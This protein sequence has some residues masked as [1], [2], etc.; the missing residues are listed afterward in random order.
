KALTQGLGHLSRRVF[1]VDGQR[2]V[3]FQHRDLGWLRRARSGSLTLDDALD[4]REHFL[5]HLIVEGPDIEQE[6]GVVRDDV[7]ARPG[8]DGADRD[9][10]LSVMPI[11]RET[12]VW[13]RITVDAAMTTGS[14][15]VCGDEPWPP[16]PNSVTRRLSL[17][18]SRRPLRIAV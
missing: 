7:R 8:L 3:A 16:R 9:T 11:S 12:T 2:K 18:D 1:V 17:W 5:A 4:R 13:S 10:A 6:R 15:V 14:T